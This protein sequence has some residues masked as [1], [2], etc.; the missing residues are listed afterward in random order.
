VG[1]H[2]VE[3]QSAKR[4]TVRLDP[5]LHRALRKRAAEAERSIDELIDDAVRDALSEDADDLAAVAG[6]SDEP[7]RPFKAFVSDLKRRGRL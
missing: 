6:R 2:N 5:K 4:A 7:T 1:C 3:M